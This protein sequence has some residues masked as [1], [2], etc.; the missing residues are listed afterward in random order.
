VASESIKKRKKNVKKN[1]LRSLLP[2]GTPSKIRVSFSVITTPLAMLV[3]FLFGK[4][5]RLVTPRTPSTPQKILVVAAAG[6]VGD[7]VLITPFLREVRKSFTDHE[8]TLITNMHG[9]PLLRLCPYVNDVFLT[10]E[11]LMSSWPLLK[12]LWGRRFDQAVSLYSIHTFPVLFTLLSGSSSSLFGPKR[13][14]L[15]P[16]FYNV[17]GERHIADYSLSLLERMGGDIKDRRLELWTDVKENIETVSQSRESASA[18]RIVIGLGAGDEKRVWPIERYIR[19]CR[20]IQRMRDASFVILG[21]EE[22]MDAARYFEEALGSAVENHVG[23]TDLNRAVDITDS[24]RMYIGNDTGLMHIAAARG[25]FVVEVSC[26][27]VGGQPWH[28]NSPKLFG[29]WTERAIVVQPPFPLEKACS[30]GC[31]KTSAHCITNISPD[32]VE[33]AVGRALA[34]LDEMPLHSPRNH[35]SLEVHSL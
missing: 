26:H 17:L 23:K 5:I 1:I 4:A 2:P 12:R 16:H 30:G 11:R 7:Q 3:C 13:G 15:L 25:L 21:T 28:L 34:S 9:Y 19:I 33:E 29:P 20:T 14:W 10:E 31:D 35:A 18:L 24:C 8:I 32:M 22:E 27:P 6:F